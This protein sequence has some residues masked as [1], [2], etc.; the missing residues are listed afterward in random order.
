MRRSWNLREERV[1][2]IGGHDADYGIEA[3]I[4]RERVADDVGVAGCL[5]FGALGR[6]HDMS[7]VAD[8]STGDLSLMP[9][10]WTPGTIRTP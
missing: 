1:R 3:F 10:T 6:P 4:E 9:V 2:K 5:D 7:A 8:M